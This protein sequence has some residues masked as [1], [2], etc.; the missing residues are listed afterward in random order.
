MFIGCGQKEIER[1]VFG[2]LHVIAVHVVTLHYCDYRTVHSLES[3]IL[4][5]CMQAH[6]L[7]RHL[8]IVF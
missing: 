3:G 7:Q 8:R 4:C 2:L 1:N 5:A 6:M